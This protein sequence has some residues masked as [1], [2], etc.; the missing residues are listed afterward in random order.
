MAWASLWGPLLRPSWRS[1]ELRDASWRPCEVT[2][3]A[4]FFK[5]AFFEDVLTEIT[6]FAASEGAQGSLLLS[7]LSDRVF[8]VSVCPVLSV[9]LS[10]SRGC[11]RAVVVR[12]GSSPCNRTIVI[13]CLTVRLNM[14][15]GNLIINKQNQRVWHRGE[16]SWIRASIFGSS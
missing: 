8:L 10:G 11:C 16:I 14:S 15:Q 9:R 2:F 4:C 3:G 6:T 5:S 1:R 13:G 7:L 12:S